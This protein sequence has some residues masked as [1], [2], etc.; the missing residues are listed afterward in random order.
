[1]NPRR[2]IATS[3]PQQTHGGAACRPIPTLST[4]PDLLPGPALLTAPDADDDDEPGQGYL[5]DAAIRAGLSRAQLRL[6]RRFDLRSGRARVRAAGARA[7]QGASRGS[8]RPATGC[9]RA[10]ATPISAASTRSCPIIG[11]CSNGSA[12]ID[13]AGRGR[14]AARADAAAAQPRPFRRFRAGDRRREHGR[15]RDGRQRLCAR[16]GGR[17]DRARAARRTR[18]WSS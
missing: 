8:T 15:D 1:M 12:N 18:R 11:A 14:H 17:A 7:V 2:P 10:A 13:R 9:S 6:F 4:D 3:T 5:W 16:H